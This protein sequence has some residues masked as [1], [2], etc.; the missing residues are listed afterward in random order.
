MIRLES[1]LVDLLE[2]AVDGDILRTEVRWSRDP[3]GCVVVASGGYPLHYE[4]GKV[5]TGLD[6]TEDMPGVSIFHAGTKCEGGRYLTTGGRVLGVCASE[7][8][9]ASTMRKIYEAC[10]RIY[11]EAMYYRRDIG[12]VKEART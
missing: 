10:G 1:D 12:A 11:F 5:I 2:A 6:E 3:S 4:K 9:L 8:T 7:D